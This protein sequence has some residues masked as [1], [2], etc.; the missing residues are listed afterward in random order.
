MSQTAEGASKAKQ[1]MKEKYGSDYYAR[2]GALG[3]RNGNT[4]GFYADKEK[5][6]EL[7]SKGGSVSRRGYTLTGYENGVPQYVKKV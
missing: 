1:T 5:A 3:G 4:G 2:I 6:R 7:G